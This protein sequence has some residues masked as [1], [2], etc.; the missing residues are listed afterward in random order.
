MKKI[1]AKSALGL[2]NETPMLLFF[3]IIRPYKG[4]HILL[5]ALKILK[6]EDI[7]FYQIVAGEFWE[8]E[9]TY[10]DKIQELGL[11]KHIRFDNRYIPDE[12]ANILFSA[13]DIFI[14]PYTSG[15]Q[16]GVIKIALGYRIP[17]V[18]TTVMVD[19]ITSH[20]TSTLVF[21][22]KQSDAED[23][24]C[25][26]KIALDT[27]RT[28]LHKDSILNNGWERLARTITSTINPKSI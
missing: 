4:L 1:D 7:N 21:P 11:S 18:T 24:A 28:V 5:D 27:S 14:A 2:A 17:I 15:T 8:D 23:L 3:G 20:L 16:S 12:E 26:I 19:E 25:T 9:N 6:T 22:C 13:C 10:R